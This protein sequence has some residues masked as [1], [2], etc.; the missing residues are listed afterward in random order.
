MKELLWPLGVLV[1]WFVLNA[2]VLPRFGV[3]T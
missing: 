1:V 3:K 2:W